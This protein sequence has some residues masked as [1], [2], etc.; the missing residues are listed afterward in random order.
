MVQYQQRILQEKGD[1]PG[2]LE[3]I[4]QRQK[5]DRLQLLETMKQQDKNYQPLYQ[6]HH[7]RKQ[8]SETSIPSTNADPLNSNGPTPPLHRGLNNKDR[9]PRNRHQDGNNSLVNHFAENTQTSNNSNFYYK[10][11]DDQKG[12]SN[13][14]YWYLSQTSYKRECLLRNSSGVYVSRTIQVKEIE[15]V[16]S[17]EL[18]VSDFSLSLF[19]NKAEINI[20]TFLKKQIFWEIFNKNNIPFYS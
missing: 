9:T 4:K 3:A 17:F 7:M 6:E 14:S 12:N 1:F 2:E 16:S 13:E 5:Q 15:Q 19:E 11:S 20:F 8:Y 18:R 10:L